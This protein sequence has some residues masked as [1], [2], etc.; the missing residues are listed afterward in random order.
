MWITIG[1]YI[2]ILVRRGS[3]VRVG[4]GVLRGQRGD[5]GKENG[6]KSGVS[7]E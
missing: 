1:V 4:C 3:D 6:S 2:A 5:E 7:I